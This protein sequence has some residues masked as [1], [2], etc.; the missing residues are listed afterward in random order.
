MISLPTR[1]LRDERLVDMPNIAN[2]SEKG[3]LHQLSLYC[4][5]LCVRVDRMCLIMR[6]VYRLT[7]DLQL[8]P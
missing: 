2:G 1:E 4:M 5:P 7:S 3:Q 6:G 8:K